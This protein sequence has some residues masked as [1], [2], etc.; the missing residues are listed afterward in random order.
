MALAAQGCISKS[1]SVTPI[2]I[3]PT[4]LPSSRLE[5][6]YCG[7]SQPVI[8][9]NT[10][11]YRD[12]AGFIHRCWKKK[13]DDPILPPDRRAAAPATRIRVSAD[14]TAAQ[15]PGRGVFKGGTWAAPKQLKP[16][17]LR[18]LYTANA[19]LPRQALMTS[20]PRDSLGQR[21]APPIVPPRIGYL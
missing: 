20:K 13:K 9:F 2:L 18:Q 1:K 14:I 8:H 17:T 19:N 16:R 6:W 7:L 10:D 3:L 15:L 5:C 12:G 11:S 21:L 4:Y